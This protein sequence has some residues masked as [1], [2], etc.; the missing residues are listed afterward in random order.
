MRQ[1]EKEEEKKSVKKSGDVVVG[2]Y[3]VGV[4][5]TRGVNNPIG[6]I[7]GEAS[8]VVRNGVSDSSDMVTRGNSCAGQ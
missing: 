8:S 5:S 2:S 1:I 7:S 6:A 3:P 4:A